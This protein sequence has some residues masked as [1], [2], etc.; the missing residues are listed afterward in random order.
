MLPLSSVAD[1]VFFPKGK[2]LGWV[3]I[4]TVKSIKS[5]FLYTVNRLYNRLIRFMF[6]ISLVQGNRG[7]LSPAVPFQRGRSFPRVR[8]IDAR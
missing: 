2:V 7:W 3:W 8:I 5:A 4:N 6:M 1:V